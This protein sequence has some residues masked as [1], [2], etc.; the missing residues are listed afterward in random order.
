MSLVARLRAYAANAFGLSAEPTAE[1]DDEHLA[2]TAL[3]VHVARV[4]GV[5]APTEVER[6]ARLVRGRYAE[7]DAEARAL[8][9]RATAMDAA[10][11]D[12]AQLVEMIGR[13]G[14]EDA[15]ARLLSMAWSVAGADGQVDEFEEAL[16]W[17]LGRLLG[18][19]EPAIAFARAQGLTGT[20]AG[21]LQIS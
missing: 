21:P 8:I 19:D 7:T 17:R 11:R 2:A 1:V 9:E 13:E 18:L 10:T 15:R 12:V 4:D 14:G 3:L 16:V 20:D 5:L 6:L